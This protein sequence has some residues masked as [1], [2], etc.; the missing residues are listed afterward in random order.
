MFFTVRS[1]NTTATAT[2]LTAGIQNE[3]FN[4]SKLFKAS[5]LINTQY[6][7]NCNVLSFC[8][9]IEPEMHDLNRFVIPHIAAKWEDVAYALCYKT[10]AVNI[11]RKNHIG[12]VIGCCKELFENWLE[13]GDGKKP[14]VWK[15]LITTLEKIDELTSATQEI[16][17]KLIQMD[18]N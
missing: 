7:N 16:T 11:I 12:D 14:K 5:Q 10:S 4:K 18:S 9:F 1:E 17:D 3:I 2:S 13:T 8:T 15:T 6:K